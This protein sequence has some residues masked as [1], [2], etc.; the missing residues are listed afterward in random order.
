METMVFKVHGNLDRLGTQCVHQ[1]SRQATAIANMAL[2]NWCHGSMED[3][4]ACT[5]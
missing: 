1:S 4:A 5:P 3:K 2:V